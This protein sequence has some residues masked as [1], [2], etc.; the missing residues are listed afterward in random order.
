LPDPAQYLIQRNARLHVPG[1]IVQL[2]VFLSKPIFQ[3]ECLF[4][5]SPYSHGA[6]LSVG[7]RRE[8]DRAI[9]SPIDAIGRA[10]MI[11]CA[12]L[13]EERQAP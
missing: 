4:E 10:A 1:L 12:P 3:G 5:T 2:L 7:G 6:L 9:S 13:I 11:W 8:R